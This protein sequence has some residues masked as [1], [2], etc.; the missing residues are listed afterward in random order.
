MAGTKTQ[1]VQFLLSNKHRFQ[2]IADYAEPVIGSNISYLFESPEKAWF[3]GQVVK[4]TKTNYTITFED[5]ETCMWPYKNFQKSMYGKTWNLL[6][7]NRPNMM[8]P[9]HIVSDASD[10]AED[11][12]EDDKGKGPAIQKRHVTESD[13]EATDQYEPQPDPGPSTSKR[14]KK[15]AQPAE[16]PREEPRIDTEFLLNIGRESVYFNNTVKPFEREMHVSGGQVGC[17]GPSGKPMCVNYKNSNPACKS[18]KI[19][20]PTE[21]NCIEALLN[22]YVSNDACHVPKLFLSD[23]SHFRLLP[24]KDAKEEFQKTY[25]YCADCKND[26]HIPTVEV[27]AYTQMCVICNRPSKKN[28]PCCPPCFALRG[29]T[30]SLTEQLLQKTVKMIGDYFDIQYFSVKVNQ[31]AITSEGTRK[32]IDIC[33]TGK[34]QGFNILCIIEKDEGQ[35]SGKKLQDENHKMVLQAASKIKPLLKSRPF[36]VFLIRYNPDDF[37]LPKNSNI[38]VQH[39]E[40]LYRLVILRQWLI[41]WLVNIKEVRT[42]LIAYMW[43]SY[44]RKPYLL[45][46]SFDGFGMI[47]HAPKPPSPSDWMYCI[48]FAE[49]FHKK[50]YKEMI[51]NRVDPDAIFANDKNGRGLWKIQHETENTE[52]PGAIRTEFTTGLPQKTKPEMVLV[53][54]GR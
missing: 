30:G 33:I 36:K 25:A 41:W 12:E 2:S 11:A 22:K 8:R 21:K 48:H 51:D 29:Q 31:T 16:E 52:I 20:V 5:S 38:S 3:N 14:M 40:H 17:I 49:G 18:K 10:D 26:L 13:D 9:S 46:S 34:Y 35:H 24:S 7:L 47:Y 42:T 44:D 19:Y 23:K 1:I 50:I 45:E 15:V 4:K 32:S 53:K 43:Y 54:K 27:R 28:D 37:T 6:K 39:Y